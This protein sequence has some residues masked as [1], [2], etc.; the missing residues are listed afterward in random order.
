MISIKNESLHESYSF[1][2]PSS[3]MGIRAVLIVVFVAYCAYEAA[4]YYH[5][6][7]TTLESV[8]HHVRLLRLPN[9]GELRELATK[10]GFENLAAQFRVSDEVATMAAWLA[11]FTL[12]AERLQVVRMISSAR[13]WTLATTVV[14][15]I[16]PQNIWMQCITPPL[17]CFLFAYMC[18]LVYQYCVNRM[19]AALFAKNRTQPA[20]VQ[21]AIATKHAEQRL[22]GRVVKE[23]IAAV[24]DAVA[25]HGAAPPVSA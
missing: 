11:A 18:Y 9:V 21:H 2:A 19:Y 25:K 10:N 8:V 13:D 12:W 24:A 20:M 5:I 7:A 3:S 23:E 17:L 15:L 22:P 16:K 14:Q 1:V 6:R 4:Q